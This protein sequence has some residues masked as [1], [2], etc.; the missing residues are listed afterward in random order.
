MILQ[1]TSPT[2]ESVALLNRRE[3]GGFFLLA[4]KI[5]FTSFVITHYNKI[6]KEKNILC[7]FVLILFSSL[8]YAQKAGERIYKSIK[9]NGEKVYKWLDCLEVIEY[10]ESG[11]IIESNIV[12]DFSAERVLYKDDHIGKKLWPT[13]NTDE[14]IIEYKIVERME[15]F[16]DEEYIRRFKDNQLVYEGTKIVGGGG[17]RGK[18]YEKIQEELKCEYDANKNI[19]QIDIKEK[20]DEYDGYE[21]D[22]EYDDFEKDY[23]YDGY[24]LEKGCSF[25]TKGN[26]ISFSEESMTYWLE[27]DKYDNLIRFFTEENGWKNYTKEED[28][29]LEKITYWETKKKELQ[30]IKKTDIDWNGNIGYY[31]QNKNTLYFE[32]NSEGQLITFKA[33]QYS[34]YVEKYDYDTQGNEISYSKSKEEET[35]IVQESYKYNSKGNKIKGFTDFI[36]NNGWLIREEGYEEY[37]LSSKGNITSFIR[38]SRDNK[39]E[40]FYLYEYYPDGGIKKRCKYSYVN[41][42]EED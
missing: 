9:I 5:L 6:M 21:K 26:V 19:V 4:E 3:F 30:S 1:T 10:D 13:I 2:A 38:R 37:H 27:Y 34:N 24:F 36:H 28:T 29:I 17:D 18:V 39:K 42:A 16:E 22:D 8:V 41:K 7:L 11:N 32:V 33:P 12:S 14:C 20:D 23:E 15:G 25:D 40:G 31:T 35:Y